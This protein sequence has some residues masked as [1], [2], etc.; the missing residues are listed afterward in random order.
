[1]VQ[2]IIGKH[3]LLFYANEHKSR[4]Q[5]ITLSGRILKSLDG[6]TQRSKGVLFQMTRWQKQ[7]DKHMQT[8]QAGDRF[9]EMYVYWV[10][11][12]KADEYGVVAVE[13]DKGKWK[14]KRWY[15]IEDFRNTYSYGTGPSY[16]VHYVDNKPMDPNNVPQHGAP[17]FTG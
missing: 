14:R 7:T 16:W 3:A 10:W 9:T 13:T 4:N 6:I 2:S 5:R 8:P 17:A 12:E 15:S 11:I 1:M